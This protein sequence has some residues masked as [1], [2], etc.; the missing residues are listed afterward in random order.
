M[1][2]SFR[3]HWCTVALVLS[4]VSV[5]LP[6]N[7]D[8]KP[9]PGWWKKVIKVAWADLKT[10]AETFGLA[11]GIGITPPWSVVVG[12]I[13]AAA[14]SIDAADRTTG[15]GILPFSPPRIPPMLTNPY[16]ASGVLH[17]QVVWDYTQ[18]GHTGLNP[19][20]FLDFVNDSSE[21]YGY[22][23]GSLT[24][25]MLRV[26]LDRPIV[27]SDSMEIIIA[28]ALSSIPYSADKDVL[29]DLLI[30]L[31]MSYEYY[32]LEGF[33][34]YYGVRVGPALSTFT[35]L[36]KEVAGS[37]LSILRYSVW[38]NTARVRATG[39]IVHT[40]FGLG[41]NCYEKVGLC[42]FVGQGYIDSSKKEVKKKPPVKKDTIN[43]NN[44][45]PTDP[46]WP[47]DQFIR[48]WTELH[49]SA[50]TIHFSA[51]APAQQTILDIEDDIR[52][53][54]EVAY[55]LGG[56]NLVILKGRYTIDYSTNEFGT[57]TV[58]C[59]SR[60]VP[61]DC[62]FGRYKERQH[63][64]TDCE[65]G[66]GA[67]MLRFPPPDGWTA[68]GAVPVVIVRTDSVLRMDILEEVVGRR[69]T[70]Y[71][72][73]DFDVDTTLSQRLGS[74]ALVIRKGA[75]PVDYNS[76]KN[77]SVVLPLV[78]TPTSVT[79]RVPA[80]TDCDDLGV[81]TTTYYDVMGQLL[82][83]SMLPSAGCYFKVTR[84][85]SGQTVVVKLMSGN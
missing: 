53:D 41:Y 29:S 40:R 10:G 39:P 15:L 59:V 64:I 80:A 50:L 85:I 57:V 49:D 9:K 36:D 6:S 4:V 44:W 51:K 38:Y 30:K 23:K 76:H 63:L 25:S 11:S 66:F 79:E 43:D 45:S 83:E 77:G 70:F 34:Q 72:D 48:S 82:N 58:G 26:L 35:T 21:K 17:N 84:C 78:P 67:C 74:S 68:D 14:G 61:A 22:R 7:V 37:L 47:P 31:M 18:S 28:D 5:L 1:R 46:R 19:T 71:V 81:A 27:D 55:S 20:E 52:L 16:E 56:Q 73:T 65:D 3:R 62:W 32:C 54:H 12:C 42:G 24:D 2:I 69:D 75:Y 33:D 8:A 13:G 60:G